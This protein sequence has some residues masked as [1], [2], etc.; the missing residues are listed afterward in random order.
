MTLVEFIQ[1]SLEQHY[2]S[3]LRAVDG[4]T[5][6]ELAWAPQ[7]GAMS[8]GFLVWHYGRTMDRWIR[9]RAQGEPQRWEQG[10][11]ARFDRLP[12]DPNDTGYGFGERQL[13]DFQLPAAP[14]LLEYASA[15]K[16][17]AMA[18][19]GGLDDAALETSVIDNPRGGKIN[20]AAMFQ[21]L[22]WE[23]NQHGGQMAYLRGMLRGIEDPAYSGGLL[24]REAQRGRQPDA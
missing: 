1:E 7:A 18:F 2:A 14:F 13:R 24:E 20:L 17:E 11:A 5:A 15:G 22:I 16:N 4:L 9:F 19:L 23:C 12:A 10:W 3:M 8:I 6:E 21:Q